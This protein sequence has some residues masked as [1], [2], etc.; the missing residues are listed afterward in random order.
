MVRLREL[1]RQLLAFFF[2]H[3]NS[4]M[5]RLRAWKT[6]GAAMPPT[7]FNSNMVRL[8]VNWYAT[9]QYY[10]RIF[11][12]QHGTIESRTWYIRGAGT[13]GI[14]I[15]TWYDWEV[16]C[17]QV[18]VNHHGYFNSNMVRL[19]GLGGG[20]G[21]NLNINFNSNMVRLRGLNK[22]IIMYLSVI[23]IPTWYDW[24]GRFSTTSL[25]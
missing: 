12:F 18:S 20:R 24:E 22:N 1:F 23:S 9:Y 2:F 8:R 19:R 10:S 11:Q 4:N 15:P 7:N 21:Q 5:V 3:F 16:I 13:C 6:G 14:S 25:M 17:V